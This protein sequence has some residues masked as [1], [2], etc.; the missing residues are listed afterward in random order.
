MEN[1][2]VGHVLIDKCKEKGH[3]KFKEY[4]GKA[5]RGFTKPV[6]A[7]RFRHMNTIGFIGECALCIYLG[8]DPNEELD[9]SAGRDAGFDLKAGGY[10]FDVKS[11]DHPGATRLMWP[12]KQKHKLPQAADILV[13]ARVPYTKKEQLG[14]TVE[15]VGWTTRDR[16]INLHWT[17]RDIPRIADGTPFFNQKDLDSM[18]MLKQ[19]LGNL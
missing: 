18:E 7:E 2:F 13:M 17:A 14:Q 16:F 1:V 15:L 19:H 3:R 5:N 9:W 4:G 12:V 8:L 6:D 11:S 10:T